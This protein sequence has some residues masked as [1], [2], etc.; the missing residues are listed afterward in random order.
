MRSYVSGIMIACHVNPAIF[1]MLFIGVLPV[2]EGGTSIFSYVPENGEGELEEEFSSILLVNLT[3]V[4]EGGASILNQV[5][6]HYKLPYHL[7]MWCYSRVGNPSDH[8][9]GR[10]R[11]EMRM[12]LKKNASI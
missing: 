9:F 7:V 6:Q 11:G 12:P 8:I 5:F 10:F 4:C 1:V 3:P 2:C